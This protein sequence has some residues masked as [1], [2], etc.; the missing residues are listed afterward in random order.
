MVADSRRRGRLRHAVLSLMLAHLARVPSLNEAFVTHR[1]AHWIATIAGMA[2]FLG[3]AS[4]GDTSQHDRATIPMA[5]AASREEEAKRQRKSYEEAK[6]RLGPGHADT[7]RALR[8]FGNSFADHLG[9]IIEATPSPLDR[10][11]GNSESR[12]SVLA[13]ALF[14]ES[15]AFTAKQRND[16]LLLE[17]DLLHQAAYAL[18]AIGLFVSGNRLERV[19]YGIRSDLLG[20]QPE[21]IQSG[22]R[23]AWGLDRVGNFLDSEKIERETLTRSETVHGP[24]HPTTMTL[25]R[26]LAYDLR[27]LARFGEAEQTDRRSLQL[28]LEVHGE[29]HEDTAAMCNNIGFDLIQ[30]GRFAEADP[31]FRRALSINFQLFGEAHSET[32]ISLSN[33]AFTVRAVG[34]RME[35]RKLLTRVKDIQHGILDHNSKGKGRK[36][37]DF[38][39]Y[40][41]NLSNLATSF[42][43]TGEHASAVELLTVALQSLE[44][45][46]IVR[47][48]DASLEPLFVAI[49]QNLATALFHLGENE[50]GIASLDMAL[51]RAR[52]FAGPGH[53]LTVRTEAARAAADIVRGKHKEAATALERCVRESSESLG[54][55]HPDTLFSRMELVRALWAQR[56]D[57]AAESEAKAALKGFEEGRLRRASSGLERSGSGVVETPRRFLA[58]FA[59]RSGK[60]TQAWGHFERDLARGLLDDLEGRMSR[61]LTSK[62][63]E[64]EAEI[65]DHILRLEKAI[66]RSAQSK[67]GDLKAVAK[68]RVERSDWLLKLNQFQTD[69]EKAYG[70]AV[71]QPF[72]LERIQKSLSANTAITAWLDIEAPP[73]AKGH[74][75]EHWGIVV[76]NS[77]DPVWV[78]LPAIGEHWAANDELLPVRVRKLLHDPMTELDA[79]LAALARQR[80]APLQK[81]LEGITRLVVLPSDAMAGIPLEALSDRYRVS[82][83]PSATLYALL[84]EKCLARKAP[85]GGLLA[86]GD[87]TY[88]NPKANVAIEVAATRDLLRGAVPRR[89]PGTRGEVE[90]ISRL[91]TDQKTEV[92][93]LLDKDAKESTLAEMAARG[94]LARFR[95]LH[96]AAH[97]YADPVAGMNSHLV[98]A[99]NT[100]SATAFS[101]LSAGQIRRRWRLDADLVTLS[102]CQTGLGEHRGGEGYIGF[103]QALLFAGAQTTVLS[104]W[105]VQDGS[106]TLLMRRFYENMLSSRKDAKSPLGPADALD[107]AR[108]WLRGV[109]LREA[110]AKLAELGVAADPNWERRNPGA[111]PF[112]HPYYWSPFIVVGHPGDDDAHR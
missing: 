54:P 86:V 4:A 84:Y 70:P 66:E 72:D 85:S 29:L 95:W 32:L 100:D 89:L 10:T 3:I 102:A 93:K 22:L 63:T 24:K 15:N 18:R 8:S 9:P 94:E 13:K 75:G 106:T 62:Q 41:R 1:H 49:H 79:D 110:S 7:Q 45:Q 26:N 51:K 96:F 109:T 97:G 48:E 30:Q 67:D 37:F 27:G 80:I 33:L 35:A 11:V 34:D 58:A 90:T 55:D 50:K 44:V 57:Q 43:S 46:A 38:E 23:L 92:V 69:L 81:H 47:R 101:K 78:A 6:Q 105:P 99:P 82:Y 103:A 91:M 5:P 104:E 42:M 2:A 71:G 17:A 59:A 64:Q 56:K 31:F 52:T 16:K 65:Q 88:E 74:P 53:P 40:C 25:R 73:A 19:A 108:R 111:R 21:T 76:R 36:P 68:L 20:D 98:L 77:G 60:A 61:P 14:I 87:P 39:F 83:A 112:T 107:E 12:M 28:L